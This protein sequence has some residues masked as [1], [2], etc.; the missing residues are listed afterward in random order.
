MKQLE[1]TQNHLHR[2]FSTTLLYCI[3]ALGICEYYKLQI[4]I[5][6]ILLFGGVFVV[7][8]RTFDQYKKTPIPYVII[9]LVVLITVII[10]INSSMNLS[11]LLSDYLQWLRQVK[12]GEERRIISE[13]MVLVYYFLSLSFIYILCTPIYFI[14]NL[15]W[16]RYTFAVIGIVIMILFVTFQVFVSHYLVTYVFTYVFLCAIELV[17]QLLAKAD[18]RKSQSITTFLIP[19]VVGYMILLSVVPTSNEPMKFQMLRNIWV[20]IQ[21]YGEEL[22]YR[23]E[24]LRYDQEE[25][26]FGIAFMGYSED[27]N[28]AGEVTDN[29]EIALSIQDITRRNTCIYLTGNVKNEFHEN[30]WEYSSDSKIEEQPFLDYE[31]DLY[32]LMNAIHQSPYSNEKHHLILSR[33]IDYEIT[34]RTT[35]TAFNP[36]KTCLIKPL[37]GL[38]EVKQGNGRVV[39]D[40]IPGFHARY[41]TKSVELKLGTKKVDE[42]LAQMSSPSARIP[43]DECYRVTNDIHSFLQMI[44]TNS[45]KI[46]DL[47]Q[48]LI[49]RRESVY[50]NYLQIP[51]YISEDIYKLTNELTQDKASDYEKLKAIEAYLNTFTY[52]T[53]PKPVPEGK[54]FLDYFLF[55]SKEGYCTYFATAMAIMSRCIGIPSRYVQG[56]C[57]PM[58]QQYY[59]YNVSGNDAHAWMDAYLSGVGWITFEATPSYG[60]YLYRAKDIYDAEKL[61]LTIHQNV[62]DDPYAS[63]YENQSIQDMNSKK[64]EL[65]KGRTYVYV[66]FI[67]IGILL[68]AMISAVCYI[69][70]RIR[71]QRN[72]FEKAKQEEQLFIL[73]RRILFLI[74]QYGYCSEENA[75]LRMQFLAMNQEL[76]FPTEGLNGLIKGYLRLCYGDGYV[77]KTQSEYMREY[78]DTL[79]S[80]MKEHHNKLT[81]YL[82]YWRMIRL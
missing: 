74:Q 66:T 20:R 76:D 53:N 43:I 45:E 38:S 10:F 70:L 23:F 9:I 36:M 63:M 59:E 6:M 81:Y 26:D 50:K 25:N 17:Y 44:P 46:F 21:E 77:T 16:L 39:F 41:K 35:K 27:A 13:G 7:A 47:S 40:S 33:E 1:F 14:V 30:H 22:A 24:S 2:F 15:R 42:F 80:Y 82:N 4:S 19:F 12:A 31:L 60:T 58:N 73:L 32:E 78:Y 29:S 65:T 51:E 68:I 56:Y 72:S 5:W 11:E 3:I 28:L 75:T 18:T 37:K 69:L 64:Q 62:L 54:E 52:T 49:E 57:V 48:A 34:S 8:L 55:E 79:L 71:F 67:A 61:D